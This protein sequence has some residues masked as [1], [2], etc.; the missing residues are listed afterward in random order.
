MLLFPL[1]VVTAAILMDWSSYVRF[2][3]LVVV[4][5]A[6]SGIIQS[7]LAPGITKRPTTESL[8]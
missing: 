6:G 2:A 5:V 4:S 7:A 3:S 1:I 8:T